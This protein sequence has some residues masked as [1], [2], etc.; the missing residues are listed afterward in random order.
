MRKARAWARENDREAALE[1]ITNKR[2]ENERTLGDLIDRYRDSAEVREQKDR[3]KPAR[4]AYWYECLGYLPLS[5]LDPGHIKEHYRELRDGDAMLGFPGGEKSLGRPRSAAT[6]NR[7]LAVLSS[8]LKY[9]VEELEWIDE[10][11]ALRVK[12]G[13]EGRGR[14][15]RLTAKETKDLFKACKRSDWDGLYTLVSLALHTGA[16]LGEILCLEWRDVDLTSREIDGETIH[17]LIALHDTKNGSA[18]TLGV[19]ARLA[20]DLRAH[21]VRQM[22]KAAEE[23]SAVPDRVFPVR[24]DGAAKVNIYGPWY[25]ALREAG[26]SGFTFHGLRHQCASEL[27]AAGAS[28]I[29]IAATLGHKTL[30]MANRYSHLNTTDSVRALSAAFGEY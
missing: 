4:L 9:G 23:G 22:A 28:T 2:D 6:C 10:N 3:T 25:R 17:G 8:C 27:A 5:E 12:R 20:D 11:P 7:Y 18:R 24:R 14:M 15:R 13:R 19:I 16:R 1:P 30:A 26:I 21:R 29:T